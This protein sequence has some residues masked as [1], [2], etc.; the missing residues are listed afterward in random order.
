LRSALAVPSTPS[1]LQATT[2]QLLMPEF[3]VMT[4]TAAVRAASVGAVVRDCDELVFGHAHG[5]SCSRGA[6]VRSMQTDSVETS[7]TSTRSRPTRAS[8][9]PAGARPRLA[10][11]GAHVGAVEAHEGHGL[12]S[13]SCDASSVAT[14]GMPASAAAVAMAGPSAWSGHRDGDARAPAAM[15]SDTALTARFESSS[16]LMVRAS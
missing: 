7:V 9:S 10:D 3:A 2:T 11:L 6:L 12:P 5:S 8:P 14:S 15:A 4:G 1:S 13:A 16:T